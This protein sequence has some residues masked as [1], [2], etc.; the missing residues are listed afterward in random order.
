MTSIK[1]PGEGGVPSVIAGCSVGNKNNKNTDENGRCVPSV[2]TLFRL[3]ARLVVPV[4]ALEVRNH[5]H[6]AH[7]PSAHGLAH[8][9]GH[10]SSR[11]LHLRVNFRLTRGA[12]ACGD[13]AFHEREDAHVAVVGVGH[14]ARLELPH[15][16]APHLVQLLLH[17]FATSRR[18]AYSLS[19][20]FGFSL[21]C[22]LMMLSAFLRS[23]IHCRAL[24]CAPR[25]TARWAPPTSFS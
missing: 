18:A 9:R 23:T 15:A 7:H 8:R 12:A 4:S 5:G 6:V 22:I 14:L 1:I 19:F 20:S 13:F 16:L 2:I 25:S 24:S 3:R 21:I 17:H 10:L 11:P